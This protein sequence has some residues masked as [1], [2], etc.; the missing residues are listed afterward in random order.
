MRKGSTLVILLAAGLFSYMARSAIADWGPTKRLTWTSGFSQCP[1]ITTD[2]S[3]VIHIV[4]QDD[5][6]I[7]APEIYYRRSIDG[8][9]TWSAARRLTWTSGSSLSPRL[10]IDSSD[11][12]HVFWA[13]LTSGNLE[14]YY[15]KST[16]H[17]AGWSATRRL[18]WT[19]GNT[20]SPDI[21]LGSSN[22]FHLVWSDATPGNA[23]IFH[24]KST[25]QGVTWSPPQRLTW[26]SGSSY[27]PRVAADSSD[28]LCIVWED[29]TPGIKQ[30]YSKRS[31]DG[32]ATWNPAQMLTGT[33]ENAMA[34]AIASDSND[35]MHVVWGGRKSGD[36]EIFYVQSA[37]GGATWSPAKRLTWTLGGSDDPAMAID[38]SDAIHVVWM[39]N[40]PGNWEVYYVAGAPG[41]TTW[42]AG[43]RVTWSS[44]E[45]RCPILTVGSGGAVHVA[46]D[47]ETPGNREIYY[48]KGS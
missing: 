33:F 15:K 11:A 9:S 29:N 14:V 36:N 6:P 38:S 42:S 17:G 41:G 25:D 32:G 45:S 47:D 35:V 23:E 2:S 10:T 20:A 31:P 1:C 40:A 27:Y 46:W 5:P 21:I 30:V 28:A 3:G 16:D 13:D 12:I 37:D 39:D 8:G 22:V 19:S 4:W 18:S 43:Q 48:R 34:P 44:G 24:K 26:T 7:G